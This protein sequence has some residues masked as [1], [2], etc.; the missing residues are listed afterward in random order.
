MA[1]LEQH[2]TCVTES[3]FYEV[4]G[5]ALA[6][7]DVRED[8]AGYL[9][10]VRSSN[11]AE[12]NSARATET[13]LKRSTDAFDLDYLHTHV[14]ATKARG[15]KV[16]CTVCKVPTSYTCEECCV[17]VCGVKERYCTFQSHVH[18]EG[19]Q[20]HSKTARTG[21]KKRKMEL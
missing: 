16:K 20:G 7:G 11:C 14:K 19:A 17:P 12:S 5:G 13:P 4:L 21:Q 18:G 6:L 1:S 3:I 10:L 9:H 15:G 2:R 8:D